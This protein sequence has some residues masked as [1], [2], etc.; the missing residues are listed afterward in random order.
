MPI[1]TTRAELSAFIAD[2]TFN[3]G[4]RRPADVVAVIAGKRPTPINWTQA[5]AEQRFKLYYGVVLD[6]R[7]NPGPG[8]VGSL[9]RWRAAA[10]AAA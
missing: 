6:A 1:W 2:R 9:R 10:L 7:G 8:L 4:R 5:P 3:P